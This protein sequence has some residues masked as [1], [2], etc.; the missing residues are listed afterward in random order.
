MAKLPSSWGT[1]F[2]QLCL[3][4]QGLGSI[5]DPASFPEGSPRAGPQLTL[6]Q[7]RGDPP[8]TRC[9]GEKAEATGESGQPQAG[10]LGLKDGG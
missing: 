3:V 9:T 1:R 2:P 7:R 8:E 4:V 5:P 10:Q 6:L